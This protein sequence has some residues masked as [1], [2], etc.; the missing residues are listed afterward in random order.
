MFYKYVQFICVA[1]F[2]F[3]KLVTDVE[4]SFSSSGI[5]LNHCLVKALSNENQETVIELETLNIHTDHTQE[6]R[7]Q[8]KFPK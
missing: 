2:N 3:S 6:V 1:L 4:T 7:L 8:I 5:G